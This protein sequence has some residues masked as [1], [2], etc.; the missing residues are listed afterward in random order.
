MILFEELSRYFLQLLVREIRDGD[1]LFA[2]GL[3]PAD[4]LN[5]FV[6]LIRSDRGASQGSEE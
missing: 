5:E 1:P 3:A 4:F 2:H 6:Q